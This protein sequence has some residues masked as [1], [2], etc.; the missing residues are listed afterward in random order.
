I[1]KICSTGSPWLKSTGGA[2]FL[3]LLQPFC[4]IVDHIDFRSAL[5]KSAIGGKQSNRTS[6]KNGHGFSWAHRSQLRCMVAGWEKRPPA[7]QSRLPIHHLVFREASQ[8]KSAEARLAKLILVLG[9]RK[10]KPCEDLHSERLSLFA[11][12]RL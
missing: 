2:Q 3:G 11:S 5:Q 6:P 8:L 12:T 4:Y 7:R 10:L 1:S 9:N